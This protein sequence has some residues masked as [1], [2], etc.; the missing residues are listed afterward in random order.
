MEL[1]SL[2][3]RYQRLAAGAPSAPGRT[4]LTIP[5]VLLLALAVISATA[6]ALIG[7][8]TADSLVP[9]KTHREVFVYNRT[10]SDDP[11]VDDNAVAAW[12]SVVPGE[13]HLSSLVNP[14]VLV[15]IALIWKLCVLYLWHRK[16]LFVYPVSGPPTPLPGWGN[17]RVYRDYAESEDVG[18]GAESDWEWGF[19]SEHGHDGHA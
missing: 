18:G 1:P 9:L 10:F 14:P 6:G 3:A 15:L 13:L 11:R 7:R 4:P 19:S 5:N 2:N 17:E 8:R 12:D 16:S